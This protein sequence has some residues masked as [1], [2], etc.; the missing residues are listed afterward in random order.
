MRLMTPPGPRRP[1]SF[2]LLVSSVALPIDVPS[3]MVV[4][5]MTRAPAVEGTSAHGGERA[6][7]AQAGD[8]S[9]AEDLSSAGAGG[10][11]C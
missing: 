4:S 3:T 10:A 9:H 11:P 7:D 5:S 6:E 8:S 2:V 1:S